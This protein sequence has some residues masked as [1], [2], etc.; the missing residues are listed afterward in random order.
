MAFFRFVEGII[1]EGK[2]AATIN[3]LDETDI[4]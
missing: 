2:A 4:T 3:K 1:N